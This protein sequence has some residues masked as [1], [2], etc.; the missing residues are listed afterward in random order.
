MNNEEEILKIN[1]NRFVLFPIKYN[2]IWEMYQKQVS[3]FWKPEEID[4]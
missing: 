1:E 2:D 4:L 3:L